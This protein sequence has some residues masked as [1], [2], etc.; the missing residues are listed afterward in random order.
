MVDGFQYHEGFIFKDLL[1]VPS[2]ALWLGGQI[3]P[4]P[5]RAVVLPFLNAVLESTVC[6]HSSV[7]TSKE[8][9]FA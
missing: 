4:P 8:H 3:D 2:C 6:P 7:P 9:P 1:C 5:F